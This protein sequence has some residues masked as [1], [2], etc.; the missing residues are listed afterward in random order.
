MDTDFEL[1]FRPYVGKEMMPFIFDGIMFR[2]V[3]PSKKS[4]IGSGDLEISLKKAYEHIVEVGL[5][6]TYPE[7]Q[8]FGEDMVVDPYFFNEKVYNLLG[9]IKSKDS[10]EK[11]RVL[12]L[13]I[14]ESSVSPTYNYLKRYNLSYNGY[15]AEEIVELEFIDDFKFASGTRDFLSL[16]QGT[17]NCIGAKYVIFSTTKNELELFSKLGGKKLQ[18][19]EK[20]RKHKTNIFGYDLINCENLF[21]VSCSDEKL[22]KKILVEKK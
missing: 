22:I 21:D 9:E 4:I 8:I 17:I 16:I 20:L 5:P 19:I 7:P 6:L 1:K 2:P 12:T 11:K 14:F 13:R 10:V 15:N 18:I 3:R